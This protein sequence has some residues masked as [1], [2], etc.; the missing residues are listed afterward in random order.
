MITKENESTSTDDSA[1]NARQVNAQ[2]SE[3]YL[4][5]SEKWHFR[6]KIALTISPRY[7]S[8][9]NTGLGGR[10]WLFTFIVRQT[11]ASVNPKLD[12]ISVKSS[13]P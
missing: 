2:P 8:S 4:A 1:K 5:L 3:I 9:V 10:R 12:Y 11:S 13:A 6:A 7:R